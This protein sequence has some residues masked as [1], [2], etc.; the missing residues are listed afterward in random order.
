MLN[1]YFSRR[2]QLRAWANHDAV[3]FGN[4]KETAERITGRPLSALR[5]LDLGCGSNAP[6]TLMLH[7]AGSQV[8][9]VDH[10]I[11]HRWGLGFR[12]SRYIDYWREAGLARTLRKLAGEVAYDSFYY[13]TLSS[14]TGLRLT[15]SGLDLRSMD[16]QNPTLPE[17]GFDVI[18]SNA[19]WEHVKDVRAANR[20]VAAALR[21]GGMV[22]IEIHLFPSLS[23]G[24]DLPWITPGRTVL[25]DVKPW[26]HLRDPAWQAPVYLNRLRERD[27]RNAFEQT[28]GLSIL[29]WRTEF[30]EGEELVTPE[31]RRELQDYDASELT[32]RSIIV[33]MRKTP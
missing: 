29:D 8:T 3:I 11:G 2:E 6:M 32:K 14:A 12:P 30:T 16:V 21:P 24:H 22:Y 10:M 15:E 17:G 27:Y 31:I 25:G 7:A 23:G 5:I 28:P 9:G 19:T 18:H 26:Q 1:G 13:R 33:V 4:F 20:T